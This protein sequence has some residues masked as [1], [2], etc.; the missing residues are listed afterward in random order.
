MDLIHGLPQFGGYD[1][2]LVVTGGLTC[3]TRAFPCNKQITG[4]Q[5]VRI[6]VE[7]LF[8]HYGSPKEVHSDED[9]RIQS[10]TGSY[11][12]VLDALKVHVIKVCPT[13]HS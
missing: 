9:V 7:Q 4:E 3:L 12:R 11:K 5:T 10:D 8:E 13:S 2:C 6:L 1:S